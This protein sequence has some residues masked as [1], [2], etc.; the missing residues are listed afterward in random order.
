[1]NFSGILKTVFHPGLFPVYLA[2]GTSLPL[3]APG[4]GLRNGQAYSLISY[5]NICLSSLERHIE[6][7]PR[8]I[9]QSAQARIELQ[10]IVMRWC[11]V[12]CKLNYCAVGL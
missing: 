7:M 1:M 9:C 3:S 2:C 5:I 11:A 8:W 12:L 10:L 6:E 4:T